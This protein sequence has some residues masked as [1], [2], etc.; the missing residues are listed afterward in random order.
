MANQ[1]Q[2]ENRLRELRIKLSQKGLDAALITKRENYIYLS[3]FTGTFANL[4]VTQDNAILVTDFR[5]VEQAKKEVPLYEIV[6]YQ[7]NLPL[8]LYELISSHSIK[9]LGFEE[10]YMTFKGYDDLC[11]KLEVI[12]LVPLSGIIELLRLV[13]DQGEIEVIKESVRVSDE[14]LPGCRSAAGCRSQSAAEQH[15]PEPSG[16][17]GGPGGI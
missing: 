2:I 14:A 7:G 4:L 12:K 8:T 16:P 17:P 11:K 13:K 15:L 5:Y 3:N 10:D 6:Q 1:N 9:N